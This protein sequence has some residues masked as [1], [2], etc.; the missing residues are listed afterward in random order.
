MGTL[1]IE[2]PSS[3]RAFDFAAK[4]ARVSRR[5]R[6]RLGTQLWQLVDIAYYR[7]FFGLHI[8]FAPGL[9]HKLATLEPRQ[10][11]G[12]VSVPR[13]V[14]ESQYRAGAWSYLRELD[15]MTRYSVIAGFI[16]TLKRDGCLLDVGCGE[17]VL[18]DRLG[19]MPYSKFV[20]IDFS[21]EAIALALRKKH[22]RGIFIQA[23]AEDFIPDEKFDFIIFNEVLYYFSDPLAVL[24]KYC[25][26][27]RPGGLFI[28]SLY[29][30]SRRARAIGRLLKNAYASVQEV[31]ITSNGERWSINVFSPF[32]ANSS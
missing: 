29:A 27:L 11:R 7:A 23:D 4:I 17:G 6:R 5:G 32:G 19:G 20:G 22:E 30:G 24:Q 25:V 28:T 16:Q 15:Q 10:D 1:M 18:L 12:D 8:P 3:Q 26:W 13:Q 9:T 14:W 2:L 21:E 31:E